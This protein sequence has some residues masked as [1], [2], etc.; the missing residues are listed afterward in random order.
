MVAKL[1]CIYMMDTRSTTG[2]DI[3]G[4]TCGSSRFTSGSCTLEPASPCL[5]QLLR[6][7]NR[8]VPRADMAHSMAL[9]IGWA[10][11]E[12]NFRQGMRAR[13]RNNHAEEIHAGFNLV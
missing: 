1:C 2:L 11:D 10:I 13:T 5:D 8:G 6:C 9:T 4:Q 3:I 12:E 7:P